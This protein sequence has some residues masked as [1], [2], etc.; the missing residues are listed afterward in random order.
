MITLPATVHNSAV[1]YHCYIKQVEW[2]AINIESSLSSLG[3][4]S[5]TLPSIWDWKSIAKKL[6]VYFWQ[7]ETSD[8]LTLITHMSVIGIDEWPSLMCIYQ[9]NY[10][11]NHASLFVSNNKY[12]FFFPIWFTYSCLSM[13]NNLIVFKTKLKTIHFSNLLW[14]E[15]TQS[16]FHIVGPLSNN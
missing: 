7:F 10:F 2:P 12:M 11:H 9:S 3:N 13:T 15:I 1:F 6:K 16:E 8:V 4:L 5:L 14:K